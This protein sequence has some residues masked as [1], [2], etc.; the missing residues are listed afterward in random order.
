MEYLALRS[1]NSAAQNV[2]GLKLDSPI[3][4][5]TF[6]FSTRSRLSIELKLWTFQVQTALA[7]HK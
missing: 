3:N 6:Q 7:D 1:N 4:G 5:Q 2:L